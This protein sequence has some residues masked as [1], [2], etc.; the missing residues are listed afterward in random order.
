[1]GVQTLS[2]E[3]PVEAFDVRVVS[4]FAWSR[5]FDLDSIYVTPM[6]ELF[7][8]ELRAVIDFDNLRG[9]LRLAYFTPGCRT[10]L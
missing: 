10:L 4:R 7:A 1:M 3:C 2:P 8:P 6:I 5:V 9:S